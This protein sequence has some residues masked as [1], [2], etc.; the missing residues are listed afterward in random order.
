[1]NVLLAEDHK[2]VRQGTRFYLESMGVNVVGEATNGREAVE[3]AGT[4]HP[5]VVVMDI[6]LPELTG[7]EA[8]RRIRHDYPD[9]RI[10]VLTAYDEPAYVHALLDAGADG[11]ILKTAELA[12]LYKALNEVAVGRK[13]YDA[14]TLARA[15]K[16]I[17]EMSTQIEGLTDRELEV[18]AQASQGKTNKEIGK[19]LFISDRTV[20][21]HLKNIY[22]KFG[23]TSRTEAVAIALQHGFISMEGAN[24][25]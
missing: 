8:T 3:M 24:N 22:Q 7:V 17:S 2:L 12:E 19:I 21:G 18:L 9:I 10:L 25:V 20:Q 5:D 4:H 13:V 23:V 15:R 1:M 16:H 6:H 14:E 11:F